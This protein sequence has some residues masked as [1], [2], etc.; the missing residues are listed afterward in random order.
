[1]SGGTLDDYRRKRDFART[2]EP[3][4]ERGERAPRRVFVVHR[5]EAR[6]LHYDLRMEMEGALRSWAVPKGFSYD[7][8]EKR[9]AVHTEDH[10]LSYERFQGVI[11]KGQ[12]GAGTMRIWDRGTY[13]VVKADD[14]AEAVRSGEFKFV[15]RGRRLRGE[16]H[17][18]RTKQGDNTWLLFKSRDR[19]AGPAGDSAL[20]IDIASA[21][22]RALP[23]TVRA[24]EPASK[25]APFADPAWLFEAELPGRRALAEKR[26]DEVR[27]RGL[28]RRFPA[29]ERELARMRAENALLDGVLVGQDDEGRPSDELLER[30]LSGDADDAL[31]YYAFDLL[32]FDEYDLRAL[33][34]VERKV[35]L[36]SVLPASAQALYVDHVLGDGVALAGAVAGAG[37]AGLVAK[38]ADAAYESG[39]SEAWRAVDAHAAAD[40]P[41][42]RA[43]KPSRVRITNPEKV[44]WP[45]DGLT[46]GDLV[47][48]YDFV[49]DLLIPHL[50]NRPVHMNR[51]PDGIHGKQFYQ[52]QA[53][54]GTPSWVRLVMIESDTHGGPV[55]Q[56]VCDD[57]D[58]LLYLA[59]LGSIDLHPWLSRVDTLDSPDYA[60]LDLDPKEAPFA[61][62]VRIAREIG[63]V[64]RG[65][66]LRPLLKTSGKTG[67]HVYV[68]LEPGYTYEQARM[69]CETVAL[70]VTRDMKEIATVERHIAS[71]EGRVYVDYGQNRRGQTVVPPYSVRP[72][73]GASVSMPLD[74]DE[75]DLELDPQRFTIRTALARLTREGDLFRAALTDKQRLEP[76]IEALAQQWG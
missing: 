73:R 18:V 13:D 4:P 69:F 10:P 51:F 24:M 54:E 19:Y 15:L 53:K 30:A 43:R 62:V 56:Y 38:R 50:A 60:V 68:P 31:V 58:T 35:A 70:I 2:P 33:P 39:K 17:L 44:Y 7:P 67:L 20:G 23:R 16:W 27:L 36:R 72:V 71:R 34:L 1:M 22:Q 11:P 65:I 40:V 28:R 47:A 26:G 63:K 9:L 49:A 21:P 45:E 6:R 41:S 12:Y 76:A 46:K 74:W 48:W 14:P 3:A 52:R 8:S 5:H 66:E 25:V 64:L 42:G 29:L 61:D 55:P 59:N 75:L 37:L 57:R 32:Y